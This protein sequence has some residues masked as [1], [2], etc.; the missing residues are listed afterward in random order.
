MVYGGWGY[1]SYYYPAYYAPYPAGAGLV[2]SAGVAVGAAVWG[3]CDWGH[4]DVDI[5]IDR[6]N[7]F[8]RNTSVNA[9]RYNRSGS[10]SANWEHNAEHRRGVNYQNTQTAQKYGGAGGSKNV[11]RDQARGK[12]PGQGQG[13]GGR[14]PGSR[15]SAAASVQWGRGAAD[16]ASERRPGAG[17]RPS[18]GG[19]RPTTL[20]S[21]ARTAGRRHC[22][23]AAG[24][25][26]SAGT[27]DVQKPSGRECAAALH[28]RQVLLQARREQEQR[29]QR[30][31]QPQGRYVGKQSRFFEPRLILVQ[32]LEEQQRVAAERRRFQTEQFVAVIQ[33]RIPSERGGGGSRGGGGG[34]RR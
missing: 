16:T 6:Y 5:D 8:N 23:P 29:L 2:T 28:E 30:F 9:E 1:P 10:G 13:G 19:E 14:E 12:Q 31:E 21:G 17:S 15:P 33:W 34:G 24:G 26:A 20:P 7:N 3:H 4:N 11:T 27:R 25:G 32:R 18:G 22:G